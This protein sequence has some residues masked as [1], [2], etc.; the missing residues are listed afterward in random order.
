[1]RTLSCFFWL[2]FD[3]I[4]DMKLYKSAHSIYKTQYHIVWITRYR[5]KILVTGVNRYLEI[6]LPEIR[7]Y[8]PDWEYLEIGIKPDH[9]HLH[10][11]IPPKYAVSMVVETIKKNTSRSL[12][13]KF[14]FLQKVYWDQKEYLGE[15]YFVSTVGINEDVIR[16][17]VQSQ[18]EEE[19]GQAQLE[20]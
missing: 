13:R 17:Y 5:R 14:N 16:K 20:F 4:E 18:A 7:K 15:G 10:M 1:M 11:V 8:Y 9:V 3:K 19:T 2:F 6:K 12:S